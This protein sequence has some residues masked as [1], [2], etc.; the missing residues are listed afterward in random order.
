MGIALNQEDVMSLLDRLYEQAVNGI[1]KVS[2][3]IE[4]LAAGYLEKIRMWKLLQ[5]N[6][7]IIRLQNA[8][9]PDF[10]PDWEALSHSPSPFPPM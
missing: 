4:N 8:P 5:K 6:S 7:S 10:L 3:P 9:L 2:P 1:Q